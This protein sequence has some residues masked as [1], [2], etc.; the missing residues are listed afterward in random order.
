MRWHEC[1]ISVVELAAE[2]IRRVWDKETR[3][4]QPETV[5]CL[6]HL[7]SFGFPAIL[8][9]DADIRLHH[10]ELQSLAVVCN[11]PQTSCC[12]VP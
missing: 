12:D 7:N 4:P 6:A 11:V 2:S 8:L 5:S 9:K 3:D 10:G 1:D